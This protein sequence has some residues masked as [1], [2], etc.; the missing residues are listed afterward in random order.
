MKKQLVCLILA[1]LL[2][3]AAGCAVTEPVDHEDVVNLPPLSERDRGVEITATRPNLDPDG[4]ATLPT[5]GL[6]LQRPSGLDTETGYRLV[7]SE[8]EDRIGGRD[9]EEKELGTFVP[10]EGDYTL[11]ASTGTP[12]DFSITQVSG[13]DSP[14]LRIRLSGDAAVEQQGGR[15]ADPKSFTL[16]VDSKVYVT[17]GDTYFVFSLVSK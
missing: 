12:L 5:D 16:T 15:L 1:A 9:A 10:L 6:S 14:E 3:L 13:T 17:A 7:V 4:T 11:T 8:T 2:L